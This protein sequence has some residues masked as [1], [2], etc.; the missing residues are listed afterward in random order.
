[1]GGTDFQAKAVGAKSR[2]TAW[3]PHWEEQAL[4][5][6]LEDNPRLEGKKGSRVVTAPILQAPLLLA[7]TRKSTAA[8]LLTSMLAPPCFAHGSGCVRPLA[9]GW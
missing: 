1:M 3:W 5:Q 4:S 6:A 7:S 8:A 9:H 2:E